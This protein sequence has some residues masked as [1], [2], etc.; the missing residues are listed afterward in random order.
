M[1]LFVPSLAVLTLVLVGCSAPDS[2]EDIQRDRANTEQSAQHGAFYDTAFS[3]MQSDADN[4]I[5]EPLNMPVPKDAGGGFTH[6]Q[7]KRNAKAIYEA[8]LLYE[9]TSD[10]RYRDH[11]VRL[12]E[13]YADMYPSL[14]LHPQ[15]KEQ[16]PGR[17]FWQSLNEAWFL[18]YAAQGYDK[19]R[20]D[21]DADTQER[22]E[23]GFF[24]PIANFLSEG[25]PE[26]FNKIHNHGTWATAAVG[27]T[28]YALDRQ[29]YVD[30]ALLGLD[31]SGKGG[32]L[33]QMEVLFSPDG[34]YN[35]G[36][37]Y[38]RYA[39]MPFVLF[40][41]AIEDNEPDRDIFGRRN[42]ILKKAIYSTIHQNYAGLFFPINDAIKDKGIATTELL[43]GVAIAYDLT[44]DAELLSVAQA[45]GKVMPTAAGRT[46]SEAIAAGKAESFSYR[47]MRLRDGAN[48]DSG[49]LDILRASDDPHGLAAVVKNTSMG[50]GHGH[51]DKLG[52]LVFDRGQEILRDYGAAR[53]LNIEAKYGGHYL[54]ENNAYAKQTIAHN[55]LVVDRKSHFDGN[56]KYGNKFAPELGEF[57]TRNAISATS[58]R[59]DSAYDGVT[60][61]RHVALVKHDVLEV[62]IIVDVVRADSGTMHDYDLPY[63]YNGQLIETNYAVNADTTSR[64]PLGE[65]SGY[66]YLWKVGEADLPDAQAQTTLLLDRRFYTLTSA[67]PDGT[68]VLLTEL[69]ANDPDTNLRREPA[70]ILRGPRAT[71]FASATVFE[72]HG[73]YNPIEEYTLSGRSQIARVDHVASDNADLVTIHLK[74]GET[75]TVGLSG[76]GGNHII[77]TRNGSVSWTGAYALIP[78][79]Q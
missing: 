43:H 46:V 67:V 42:D 18:V 60:L 7:H 59:I 8:G 40:A 2:T 58:A 19:I 61:T 26:T 76:D 56:W 32:F 70:L 3:E 14:G 77:E 64:L 57:V 68:Q 6:E 72:P 24:H 1:R 31:L 78:S 28:G 33:R 48:G 69:G 23:N 65:D 55:A 51:F 79:G 27:L 63:H 71:H 17:L 15:Q 47:S 30:A 16:S 25:Q 54:A 35:E 37:Y 75:I 34:Y 41:Q 21:L 5:A 38:Q 20:D 53:F 36:P 50:L 4:Q 22:I 29:D 13:A 66:Q 52:L 45:Q 44:A 12:L 9:A 74:S 11:A 62:P 39:L 73:E 49:A 10:D